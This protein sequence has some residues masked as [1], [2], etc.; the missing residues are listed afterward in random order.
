MQSS[1]LTGIFILDQESY[2]S[3]YSPSQVNEIKAL[4]DIPFEQQTKET[5]LKNPHFL[6]TIDL[7]FSGW[8]PPRI[9]QKFLKAAPNLKAVFYGAG[10]VREIVTPEF[11]KADVRITS[12]WAM[13]AIP[14]AEYT[15]SQ[16]L[17]A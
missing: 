4:I 9:D 7:I 3:I 16:I 14:V 6:E 1:K 15:L 13:N 17:F 11:W 2:K 12:A 5:I 10:S 8:G